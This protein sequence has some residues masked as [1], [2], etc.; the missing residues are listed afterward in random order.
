MV[1]V[2]SQNDNLTVLYQLSYANQFIISN[3]TINVT[4]TIQSVSLIQS[5][6]KYQTYPVTF[7]RVLNRIVGNEEQRIFKGRWLP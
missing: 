4:T 1:I 7:R 5:L 6:E 2:L 3:A